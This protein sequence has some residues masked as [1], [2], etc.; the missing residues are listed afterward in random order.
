VTVAV[1]FSLAVFADTKSSSA[2]QEE[3][4]RSWFETF[5]QNLEV[6]HSHETHAAD[7]LADLKGE[8]ARLEKA[9][10]GFSPAYLRDLGTLLH[11]LEQGWER[12][13]RGDEARRSWLAAFKVVSIMARLVAAW[14]SQTSPS[15]LLRVFYVR[16]APY[17]F[18]TCVAT[19]LELD[20][21]SI[22]RVCSRRSLSSRVCAS[23]NGSGTS[24][25]R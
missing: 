16:T 23:S 25:P 15:S 13:E 11:Q 8:L 1:K 24:S 5:K 18:R 22:E 3:E 7:H 14:R 2:A 9:S 6:R 19:V 4:S 10:L 21:F 17:L 20:D 12:F